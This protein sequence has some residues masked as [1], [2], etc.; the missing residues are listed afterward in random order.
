MALEGFFFLSLD[1]GTINVD[2]AEDIPPANFLCEITEKEHVVLFP[3]W[4][5]SRQKG[6]SSPIYIGS[7]A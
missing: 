3:D 5:S 1:V 7:T 6:Q 2:T 4:D